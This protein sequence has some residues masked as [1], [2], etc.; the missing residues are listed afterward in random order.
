[1]ATGGGARSPLW[2]QIKADILGV[3]VVT[4]A[5]QERACLGAAAFAAVAAGRYATIPEALLAMVHPD[6]T[7]EPNPQRVALYRN[8]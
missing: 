2:L 1:V 6:R 8:E 3:P 5:C 7:F 4:P